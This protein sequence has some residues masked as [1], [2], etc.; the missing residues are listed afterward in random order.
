MSFYSDLVAALP[1]ATN[2][3]L[4]ITTANVYVDETARKATADEEAWWFPDSDEQKRVN[5]GS[6]IVG[7]TFA[8][9]ITK[10][11]GTRA[12]MEA[13][14][15]TLRQAW[16]GTNPMSAVSGLLSVTV[17]TG[18]V[19]GQSDSMGNVGPDI[20]LTIEVTFYAALDQAA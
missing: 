4:G 5:L 20:G 12:D 10:A 13:H 9:L 1:A 19:Q 11:D 6:S 16:D 14:L 8:L 7:H 2:T 18:L 15:E 3:A 17:G